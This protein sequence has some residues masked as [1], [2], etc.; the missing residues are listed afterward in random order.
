MMWVAL[1][2]VAM[3]SSSGVAHA[4]AAEDCGSL[5]ESELRQ[6]AIKSDDV[7]ISDRYL[8]C[9]PYG[10][11]AT[12]VREHRLRLVEQGQCADVLRSR[13]INVLRRYVVTNAANPCA[14]LAVN[15]I[16]QL[17]SAFAYD[18]FNGSELK[19]RLLQAG[20]IDDAAACEDYCNGLDDQCVGYT[21]LKQTRACQLYGALEGRFVRGDAVSGVRQGTRI[22][23][24][25]A[26][27][28][29]ANPSPPLRTTKFYEHIDLNGGDFRSYA[30]ITYSQCRQACDQQGMCL[31]FTYNAPSR[32]CFLKNGNVSPRRFNGAYSGIKE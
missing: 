20:T 26:P 14:A 19:G 6:T 17:E 31:G 1:L 32:V 24:A 12:P 18:S 15:R 21:F 7:A 8:R 29:P 5:S 30:G 28:A 16:E 25:T 23:P 13:D 9:F 11:G 22:R 27:P 10:D 3:V 2:A 4:V